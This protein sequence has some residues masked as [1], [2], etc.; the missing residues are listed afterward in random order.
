MIV[1]SPKKPCRKYGLL[2]AAIL[3]FAAHARDPFDSSYNVRFT[4]R[5]ALHLNGPIDQAMHRHTIDL[6]Q[7]L[8][9]DRWTGVFGA[10]AYAESAFGV[11]SRYSSHPVLAAESQEFVARDIYLQYKGAGFQTRLGW[12]QVVWGESYGFFFADIVNPKDT[13]EFGLG[14]DLTAQRITVPMANVV[15]FLGESTVQVLYIPKPYFN[16]SPALGSDFAPPIGNL[17]P[18]T[19]VEVHDERTKALAFNNGEFGIRATT[20]FAGWDLSAFYFNYFDRRPSYRP[21]LVGPTI[22][23]TAAHEPLQTFGLTGT[24]DL[25][26]WVV[27]FESALTP[28]RPVDA[29]VYDSLNPELS[30]Y[31]G[32]A[33]EFLAVAGFDYTQWKDWRLSLQL[34]LNALGTAIPG[35]FIRQNALNL[36]IVTGGTVFGNHEFNLITNYANDGSSLWQVS[37]MVPISSRLEATFGAHLFAGGAGSQFGQFKGATRAF[38]Q[39]RGFFSGG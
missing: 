5:A 20:L 16:L 13:R 12:Q 7:T 11:N 10:R 26:P 22:V 21:S 15:A 19:D 24:K 36:S 35:A 2:F 25:G 33:D 32:H 34:S 8:K 29:Y 38:V 31:S 1:S 6:E 17:F 18:G 37:Y 9:A 30:Y 3:S 23:A 14:G 27:R 4:S 28:Q 39:I